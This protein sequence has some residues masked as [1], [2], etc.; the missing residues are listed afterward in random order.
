[1]S[2]ILTTLGR[3]SVSMMDLT[4]L[5]ECARVYMELILQSELLIS[6]PSGVYLI[7]SFNIMGWAVNIEPV[8]FKVH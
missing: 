5:R 1:M 7:L 3:T 8:K 2:A 6:A 4:S